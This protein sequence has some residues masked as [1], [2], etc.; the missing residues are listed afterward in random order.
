MNWLGIGNDLKKP[1]LVFWIIKVLR[2]MD[3]LKELTTIV[4]KHKIKRLELLNQ[5][6]KDT[7]LFQLYNGI[8]KNNFH[9]DEEAFENLYEGKGN[10]ES[11]LKLKK[12]LQSKL[13]NTIFF[14]DI[15]KPSFSSLQRAK[16]ICNKNWALISFL[17]SKNAYNSATSLARNTLKVA[18]EFELTDIV[19]NT[20]KKL[21]HLANLAGNSKKYNEYDKLTKEY[22]I[23]LN[24]ELEA[25][26]YYER[27]AHNFSTLRAMRLNKKKELTE[28]AIEL[29]GF[30][31]KYTDEDK[32]NLKSHYL[33]LYA[34]LVYAM[35]YQIENDY[36]NTLEV[37]KKAVDYFD[38][39]EYSDVHTFTFLFKML[40][41]HVQL[42][43]Y[44]KGVT[45]F[46]RCE[47]LLDE[48]SNNWF[49]THE[50][51]M[52]LSFH[53]KKYQEAY[54]TYN[55]VVNNKKFNKLSKNRIENWRI[56]EAYIHYFIKIGEIPTESVSTKEFKLA[57]FLNNVPTFS[58]DKRGMNIPIL[59][60]QVLFLLQRK[61]YGK[62]IDLV[63]ALKSYCYRYLRDDETFRS[64][65]FIKML[66]QL[67]ISSFH[68]EGV[69]RKTDKYLQKLQDSPLDLANQ[70]SEIEIVPYEVLWDY[71]M[72]NLDNKFH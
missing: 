58:K 63:E 62:V 30:L 12:R 10:N 45:I 66:L 56:Y 29:S 20:A 7:K 13:L 50:L 8:I 54:E 35:R 23:L 57:K 49:T 67:P 31:R 47:D 5:V 55:K 60:I 69:K 1:Y 39:K 34:Y 64:N 71:V 38:E 16:Y 36:K 21:R 51:Y 15:D 28:Q 2:I 27:L 48:G 9:S 18:K 14:I 11:F 26:E 43:E 6:S 17:I 44:D 46:K 53:T 61:E 22:V 25:E 19:I 33:Y 70:L 24:A 3:K 72:Q 4:N 59:I 32:L 40:S 37:C 65:C 41:C 42:K 68:R 52:I